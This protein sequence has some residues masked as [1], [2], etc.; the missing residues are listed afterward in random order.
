MKRLIFLLLINFPVL[1][2]SQNLYIGLSP[3]DMAPGIRYDHNFRKAGVYVAASRGTY[4]QGKDNL[5]HY[6]AELGVITRMSP[7][8]T[9]L[10]GGVSVHKYQYSYALDLDRS[11]PVMTYPFSVSFG[12]GII[13]NRACIAFRFDPLKWEGTFEVGFRLTKKKIY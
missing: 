9:F 1:L 5:L 3:A 13:I 8:N 6:K 7:I 10:T 12:A 4:L 2:Y 11:D